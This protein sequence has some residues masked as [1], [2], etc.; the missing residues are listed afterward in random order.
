VPFCIFTVLFIIIIIIIYYVIS[1]E[2]ELGQGQRQPGLRNPG[3]PLR[4]KGTS[5]LIVSGAM[6]QYK[7]CLHWYACRLR[8]ENKNY[9]TYI[10]GYF[11]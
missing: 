6:V 4:P 8:L 3:H 1:A 5:F 2:D 7:Y 9:Y 11:T 10:W